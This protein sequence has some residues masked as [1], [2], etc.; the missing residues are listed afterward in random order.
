MPSSLQ[1]IERFQP[2]LVFTLFSLLYVGVIRLMQLHCFS[3]F[4]LGIYADALTRI[5][6]G[7]LNPYIPGRSIRIFNDHFDPILVPFSIFTR[8]VP[9]PYLGLTLDF[10]MLAACWFPLVALKRAKILTANQTV[11]AYAFLILNAAM[12]S[13]LTWPFHPTTWAIL[14]LVCLFT[15]YILERWTA[16]ALSFAILCL[17]REEFPLIGFP[18]ALVLAFDRKVKPAVTIFVIALMWTVFLFVL[19]PAWFGSTSTYG[20]DLLKNFL[21]N[22]FAQL[23]EITKF[24][25]IRMW[26]ERLSPLLL[27][28][29]WASFKKNWRSTLRVLI[30]A[31]PIIGIRYASNQW[32]FHYGPAAVISFFFAFVLIFRDATA[33][34]WR[35]RLAWVLIF[36]FF[37][38]PTTKNLWDAFSTGSSHFAYKNC[39]AQP[40]RLAS[41]EKAQNWLAQSDLKRVLM[42]NNLAPTQMIRSNAQDLFILAGPQNDLA[43]TYDAVLVEKNHHGDA[44]RIGHE[45]ILD[46]I[47][48]YKKDPQIS[49]IQ[50]DDFVFLAVGKIA[51]DR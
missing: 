13:A 15:F 21:L 10:I 19:R 37:L 27:V 31:S 14:P 41:I 49:V 30:I 28:L 2:V 8:F 17:F 24:G 47:E 6:V 9:A 48:I 11:F 26:L 43:A 34:V 3:Y 18:L 39:P 51:L 20:Q 35:Q 40:D 29:S 42:Q 7:D 1:R 12:V 25:S 5:R 4:D 45:R 32:A 23:S 44:W 22:P 36:V 46:L 38:S 50:D 33:A 16:L